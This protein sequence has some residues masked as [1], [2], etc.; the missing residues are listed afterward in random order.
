MVP[1]HNA[2]I[3]KP[4]HWDSRFL[5]QWLVSQFCVLAKPGH[6]NDKIWDFGGKTR[7]GAMPTQGTICT[8]VVSYV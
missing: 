6:W 2:S 8:E 4:G 3:A 7:G 5:Y 1:K